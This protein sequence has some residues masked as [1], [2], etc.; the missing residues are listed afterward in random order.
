MLRQLN[1]ND[2][3]SM[4]AALGHALPAGLTPP[5]QWTYEPGQLRLKGFK[6]NATEQQ[7]LQKTLAKDG[8]LWRA[9]GDGWLMTMAPPAQ[10][11]KP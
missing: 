6:P 10:E 8:Y 2:L 11:V 7:F 9:E 1:A 5:N 4:L 3:E